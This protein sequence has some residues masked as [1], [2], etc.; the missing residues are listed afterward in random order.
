MENVETNIA[1]ILKLIT[2]PWSHENHL[3]QSLR[4]SYISY[5]NHRF[6][7]IP[8]ESHCG[9]L[10]TSLISSKEHNRFSEEVIVKSLH[11]ESD[12]ER[13]IFW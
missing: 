1:N 6:L 4:K 5:D 13:V 10:W 9:F 3:L 2:I 11:I 12:D 7:K 8:Y